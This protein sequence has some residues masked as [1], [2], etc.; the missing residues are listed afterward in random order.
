VKDA[1]IDLLAVK[2]AGRYRTIGHQKQEQSAKEV[3]DSNRSVQVYF[4][5]GDFP[6]SGGSLT[7]PFKF[8]IT[9]R[10]DLTVAKAAVGDLAVIQNPASTPAQLATALSNIQEAT[11]LA[12]ESLDELYEI[13]FQILEDAEQVEFGLELGTVSNRWISNLDKH[14]PTE[15]GSLVVLTGIMQL[16]CSV[17]EYVIGDQGVDIDDPYYDVEVISNDQ[18]GVP[19]PEGKAGTL[20]GS[21]T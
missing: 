12:D 7:G 9:Y 17:V 1:I 14:E 2:A 21:G 19:D 20:T 11:A 18:N 15:R 16:T 6:K 10:I 4:S 13:V 8:D 5:N 3:K